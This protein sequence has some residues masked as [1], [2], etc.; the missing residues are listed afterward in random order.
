MGKRDLAARITHARPMVLSEHDGPDK[1]TRQPATGG[2]PETARRAR[3][4][5]AT[6]VVICNTHR[7][8]NA[9]FHI[10]ANARFKGVLTFNEFPQF[11]S[12]P[13]CADRGNPGLGDATAAA[14]AHS[15]AFTPARHLDSPGPEHGALAP[16]HF[17]SRDHKIKVVPVAAWCAAHAHDECRFVGAAIPATIEAGNES[18]APAASG[19]LGH[20]FRPNRDY[21]ASRGTFT[22]RSKVNRQVD[23]HALN[24]WHS[25]DVTVP[26]T[27]PGDAAASCSGE[28]SMHDTAMPHGAPGRDARD[29]ECELVT[30]CFPSS[31]TGQ[32]DVIFP[33]T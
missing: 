22:I 26:R 32:T 29:R 20:R 30:P 13:P 10:N 27:L 25:G 19:S 31:G 5:G 18:V 14:A 12:N 21:P 8:P 1:G 9:G 23:L 4:A 15:G 3:D 28:G 24:M 2:H 11:I 7:V 16:T 33:V 6:P 17:I